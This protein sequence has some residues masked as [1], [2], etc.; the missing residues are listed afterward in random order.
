VRRLLGLTAVVVVGLA[1]LAAC[2]PVSQTREMRD[3]GLVRVQAAERVR[4]LNTPDAV[5]AQCHQAIYARY[6]KTA[7]A[8]GSGLA[9]DGMI[10][11]G[12]DHAAS[13]VDYHVFARDGED[14]MS[15]TR[16][17]KDAKGALNGERRLEFFIGSGHRGRTFLYEDGDRWFELPINFYTRRQVWD[18]APAFDHAERMPEALPVDP[19]CL[20]CHASEVQ[21]ALPTARNRYADEPFTQGGVGCSACH[22]DPAAHLAQHGLGPIVNPAKLTASRRDSA[23]IQCHLEGDAVVYRP[24][25]SLAQFKP[26]DELSD[27]A[28]YFVKA[29]EEGDGRRATSQYEALLRSACKR[30]S[31]DKLTCTSCHDPHSDV[32]PA[33]RVQYYRAKCLA[34]HTDRKMASHHADEQD[35]AVCHMPSRTTTDISHEQV[36]DHDIEA[37]PASG[38]RL[39]DLVETA[40]L[41]PV[42]GFAPSWLPEKD[43]TTGLAYAQIAQRGDGAAASTALRLLTKA[44]AAGANDAEL[45]VRLGYLRQ[46]SGDA[47]GARAAYAAVLGVDPYEPTALANLAV[48]DAGSGHVQEALRLL[49]R[50]TENDPSQAA[51]GLNLMFI[52]CRLGK[53]QDAAAL[54]KRLLKDNPD[55]GPL[56][57]FLS[58][59]MYGGERCA[60]TESPGEDHR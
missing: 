15:F 14:W 1:W 6:E 16:S 12:F 31:G 5:C 32:A 20:H 49:E 52:D 24:G 40:A 27:Y 42:G 23:C 57:E 38:V 37:R 13:G 21:T 58:T 36:T 19:N 60:L 48:L 53:K 29:H 25:R 54:S 50:L 2:D 35:C 47:A 3:T 30:A 41:V 34:C 59:G 56:R 18:M 17:A 4:T 39:H 44:S 55:F 10:A 46:V 7:M 33:E 11:G 28:V 26:G 43:R 22:G 8:R 45:N 51:A 9:K